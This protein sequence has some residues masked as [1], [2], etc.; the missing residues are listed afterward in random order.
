MKKIILITALA[1]SV[2]SWA[3]GQGNH[4]ARIASLEQQVRL[5][6]KQ[7]KYLE[8]QIALQDGIN[9]S[10]DHMYQC[11]IRV[12]GEQYTGRSANRG[13]AVTKTVDACSDAQ[14]DMFCRP[15]SVQ[16]QKY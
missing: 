2:P 10:G 3:F 7:I 14:E 5:L 1:F 9:E 6:S 12:F 4:E 13:S 15:D 11:K 8:R 16:C